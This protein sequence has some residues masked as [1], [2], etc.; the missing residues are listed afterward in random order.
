MTDITERRRT[1]EALR[2]RDALLRSISDN[3]PN[4]MLYQV[5][6][7]PEG[8]R[9]F[10]YVSDA[11]RHLY[12][13]SPEEAMANAD[14]IYGRVL[15]ED[16]SRVWEEEEAAFRSFSRF[17]TEARLRNPSGE[18]RW[19]FFASRPRRL[20]DGLTC[21]DG[22]EIEITERKRAEEE[23]ARN[24]SRYRTLVESLND[25]L[26]V[27]DENNVIVYVNVR[28]TE[29]LGYRADELLGRSPLEFLDEEGCK[30]F[31][32]L[33]AA[34]RS[35]PRVR[36]EMTLQRK[37]GSALPVH[38][39]GCGVF[40]ET[41]AYRGALAVISD[42]TKQRQAEASLRHANNELQAI[43]DA[44]P[45]LM[46][47]LAADGTV[48]DY[49]KGPTTRTYVPPEGFLR[50]RLQEN[51]PLSQQEGLAAAVAKVN[52]SAHPV[53]VEYTLP[54]AGREEELEGRL[55]PL[56]NGEILLLVRNITH[57]KRTERALA[58]SEAR[59]RSLVESINEGV[60]VTDE[61]N[62]VT[63]ANPRFCQ[64]LGFSKEEMHN[65]PA[66]EF[67][68]EASRQRFLARSADRQRGIPGSYELILRKK[69]GGPVPVLASEQPIID[70]TGAYRGSVGVIT[71]ITALK[72]VEDALRQAN[73]ELEAIFDAY[74][75]MSFRVAADGTVTDFR[76]GPS[77]RV[78][79]FLSPDEFLGKFSWDVLPPPGGQRLRE[80]FD[81]VK[82]TGSLATIEY[83]ILLSGRMAD[84]EARLSPLPNGEV[85]VVVRDI[86]ERKRAEE[87]LNALS[88]RLLQA[89][90][91]ERRHLAHELHDEFGQ[92]LTVSK[93]SAGELH[94]KLTAEHH[95][96]GEVAGRLQGDIERAIASVRTIQ[97]G[98]YPTILDHLGLDD[99]V[100]SLVNDFQ[101]RTGVACV[102]DMDAEPLDF[103]KQRQR[104]LYRIVQ[105][106]LTNVVR[107]SGATEVDIDIHRQGSRLLLEIRDDGHGIDPAKLLASDS[108]GLMGMRKRAEL[109]GGSLEIRGGNGEGT[110]LTVDV[111]LFDTK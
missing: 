47:R 9:R 100:E 14:R 30:Q 58:A 23:V 96:L 37:D 82:E 88:L 40:D 101:E 63:Y 49:R 26:G 56:P 50:K 72:R 13:C 85:L 57:R 87:R 92:L 68:D 84:R 99:A 2:E 44:Y 106:A 19:S 60:A 25:G 41:G 7:D 62:R 78:Q 73:A 4:A 1:E 111:P 67:Y 97:R 104:A 70:V 32:T 10:T 54:V 90:D 45:D 3:L 43:F 107:H 46:F 6:R 28:V 48:I 29:M 11:V 31:A 53:T 17:S 105:E 83:P 69:S 12:G 110:V 8:R 61:Y 65:R 98:L 34:P 66:D 64:M 22:V 102:L 91:E 51:V 18:V 16:R 79:M 52:E 71:E 42:M 74:P 35:D 93:H 15:E 95:R 38:V 59:Y 39:S 109:C 33:M 86:T 76:A 5:V 89:Q 108:Y 24:E 81:K 80:A 21:W 77:A 20:P 55:C 27:V 75:D 94:A 103:D 36:S